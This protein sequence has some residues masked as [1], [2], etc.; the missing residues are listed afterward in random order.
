MRDIAL[1]IHKLYE[2]YIIVHLQVFL[3]KYAKNL[4]L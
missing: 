4:A 1:N 3:P 2:F